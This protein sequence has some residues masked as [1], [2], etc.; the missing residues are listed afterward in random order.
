MSQGYTVAEVKAYIN[1]LEA[2]RRRRVIAASKLIRR[3]GKDKWVFADNSRSCGYNYMG[4]CLHL[5]GTD[6][7]FGVCPLAERD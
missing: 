5:S 3:R 2:G 4:V 1:G 6:C 7:L